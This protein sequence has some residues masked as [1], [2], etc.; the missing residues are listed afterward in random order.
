ML[1]QFLHLRC[2]AKWRFLDHLVGA[3][4]LSPGSGICTSRQLERRQLE[5]RGLIAG[6]LGTYESWE[7]GF[8]A[9]LLGEEVVSVTQPP[10]CEF[11]AEAEFQRALQQW[12][13]S[14]SDGE[15]ELDVVSKRVK[16][17]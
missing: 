14:E 5:R 13:S 9:Q 1:L 11:C 7:Q 10:D 17:T 2:S 15:E 16:T 6:S 4:H 3:S 12:E 8:C